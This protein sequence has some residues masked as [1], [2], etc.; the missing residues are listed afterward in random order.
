[1]NL[2]INININ[3]LLKNNEITKLKEEID[4]FKHGISQ[5]LILIDNYEKDLI[6]LFEQKNKII[7]YKFTKILIKV[8]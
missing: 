3:I 2:S 5:R 6:Q 1:M 4:C 7:I 8:I